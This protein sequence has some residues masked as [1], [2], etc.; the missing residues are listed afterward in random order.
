MPKKK[1]LREGVEKMIWTLNYVSDYIRLYGPENDYD[2]D[3]ALNHISNV[4]EQIKKDK[5]LKTPTED[6]NDFGK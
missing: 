5:E 6:V 4:V 3:F 2:H 1:V